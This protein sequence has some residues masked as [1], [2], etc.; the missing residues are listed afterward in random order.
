MSNHAPFFRRASRY[1]RGLAFLLSQPS[2]CSCRI[3]KALQLRIVSLK[4]LI[5]VMGCPVDVQLSGLTQVID[6]ERQSAAQT[7]LTLNSSQ[8]LQHVRHHSF[9]KCT[10]CE[11]GHGD[12]LLRP[13][14]M[15]QE[16]VMLGTAV[17][18]GYT[19]QG[20]IILS[21]KIGCQNEYSTCSLVIVSVVWC[22]EAQWN[23]HTD[24]K[25]ALRYNRKV[26]TCYDLW[27]LLV[28]FA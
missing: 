21:L 12:A 23:I 2:R 10:Y 11:D 4:S 16:I 26:M 24:R 6:G 14:T 27:I 5:D 22:F 13:T 9:A 20:L 15:L 3:F 18:K 19:V 25:K 17:V 28:A 8:D 1:G 7:L